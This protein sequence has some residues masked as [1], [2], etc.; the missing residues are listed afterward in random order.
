MC[1]QRHGCT[2]SWT[3]H[4]L[5]GVLGLLNMKLRN[6]NLEASRFARSVIDVVVKLQLV[7]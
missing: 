4:E 3:C 5:F 6:I 7:W 1:V 2:A